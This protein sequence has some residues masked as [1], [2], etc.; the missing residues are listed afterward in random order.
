MVEKYLIWPLRVFLYSAGLFLIIFYTAI[1]F[2]SLNDISS[3]V[4]NNIYGK[5]LTFSDIEFK[6]RILG[7]EVSAEEILFVDPSYEFSAKKINLSVNVLKSIVGKRLFFEDISLSDGYINFLKESESNEQVNY[8]AKKIY[9][10]GFKTRALEFESLELQNLVSRDGNIGFQFSNLDLNI[11]ANVR[12]LQNLNGYGFYSNRNLAFSVYSSIANIGINGFNMIDAPN[13]SGI[14]D[15]S[16][17]KKFTIPSALLLTNDEQSRVISSFSYKDLFNFRALVRSNSETAKKYFPFTTE[18]LLDFLEEKRFN[19][20]NVTALVQYISGN[21]KSNFNIVT[22]IND[23]SFQ[24]NDSEFVGPEIYGEISKEKFTLFAN[25][26]YLNE[27]ELENINITKLR[28]ENF[29]QAS[30]NLLDEPLKFKYFDGIAKNIYWNKKIPETNNFI[31]LSKDRAIFSLDGVPFLFDLD[32]G[33]TLISETIKVN[34]SKLRSNL[35][36]L[37]DTYM[38]EFSYNLASGKITGMNLKGTIFEEGIVSNNF[39]NLGFERFNFLITN[40]ELNSNE[41]TISFSGT[42]SFNGTKLTYSEDTFDL[43]ALRVLTLIDLRANIF[44]ILNL[45]FQKINSRDF[46]VDEFKGNLVFYQNELVDVEDILLSFGTSEANIIGTIE[47]QNNYLDSFNLDLKFESNISQNIPWYF[48][49]LGNLPA[50][51]GAALI[52]G[53]IEQDNET[54]FSNSFK[55]TGNLEDLNIQSIE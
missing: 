26:M 34:P 6:P 52:T 45:D 20:E 35:F 7:L 50:A 18:P 12:S 23:F 28:K 38:N 5:S 29:Y 24:H 44:D 42:T 46:F 54:L 41:N 2:L 15:L 33:V 8:F 30:L 40:G 17:D 13:L 4:V 16:F 19:A 32:Q 11:N 39:E 10:D 3:R 43:G 49:I 9:F 55:I 53:I 1:G 25:E 37:D 47:S 36:T 14:I 22:N 51:A 27:M 31:S 48:A 21:G